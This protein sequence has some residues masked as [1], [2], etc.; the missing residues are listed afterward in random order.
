[1]IEWLNGKKT[2]I[3]AI[4]ALVFNLGCSVGWWTPDNQTWV[5]IDGILASLFGMTF[6]SAISN[7]PK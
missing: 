3:V 5:A 2:Y 7:I 1:M 6:R 4:V